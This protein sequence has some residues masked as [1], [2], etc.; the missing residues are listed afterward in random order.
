MALRNLTYFG[1]STISDNI[2]TN[3][4]Y[5]LN[6][7][8]LNTGAFFNI[9][10]STS[11][12]YGGEFSRLRLSNDRNYT[13]GQVWESP[14]KQWVWQSSIES[15]VQPISISGLF[16]NNIFRPS[17][18][19][20]PYSFE[21]DYPNG[22]VIFNNAIPTTSVVKMEYSFNYFQ[23]YNS[24]NPWWLDLQ[25]NSFRIDDS[26]FLISSSGFWAKPPQKRIQMPAIVV[27]ATPEMKKI[28]YNIGN[29]DCFHEQDF[30]FYILTESNRDLK[31]VIDMITGQ[32]EQLHPAFD[33]NKLWL[34]GVYP[35]DME[36]GSLN[37]ATSNYPT[38][39]DDF[40]LNN[41]W[42]F[43]KFRGTYTDG[44]VG[45]NSNRPLFTAMIQATIETFLH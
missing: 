17:S 34:S 35:I 15:S 23:L 1:E 16:V 45:Q 40:P 36:N 9:N 11:G 12:S 26:S 22:R 14:R 38:L 21:I 32:N 30:R 8:L 3:L 31:W 24:D 44:I 39:I 2:E 20:G 37:V 33:T 19:I 43:K 10:I 4:I 41:V 5:W 42:S 6:Y 25:R 18:G 7:N 28:P 13:S 29:L 27:Q